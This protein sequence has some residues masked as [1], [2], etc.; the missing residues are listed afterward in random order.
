MWILR[1][2]YGLEDGGIKK[3]SICLERSI[4]YSIGRSSKNPLSIKNDKSISRQHITIKWEP[5]GQLHLVN[6]GKLTSVKERYLAI[7]ESLIFN[8]VDTKELDVHLG[9]NPVIV[10]IRWQPMNLYIPNMYEQ[11]RGLLTKYGIEVTSDILQEDSHIT[12][13]VMTPNDYYVPLLALA[14]G[15]PVFKSQYLTEV[16]NMLRPDN[17]TFDT[18]VQ[19][20]NSMESLKLV[21]SFSLSNNSKNFFQD[22][23]FII[24]LNKSSVSEHADKSFILRKSLQLIGGE[25]EII[26]D[27]T[28]LQN[29]VTKILSTSG[30]NIVIVTDEDNGKRMIMNFECRNVKDI[31]DSFVKNDPKLLK[32]NL[33]ETGVVSPKAPEIFE[34]EKLMVEIQEPPIEAAITEEST[35]S[36]NLKH[37]PPE[38]V[39]THIV[40]KRRLARKRVKPLESLD[41]FVGG[42]T[43]GT[44][45]ETS[46]TTLQ[47]EII[48]PKVPDVA[49][50][51]N[52][53]IQQ[54]QVNKSINEPAKDIYSIGGSDRKETAALTY[55]TIDKHMQE[56]TQQIDDIPS[57]HIDISPHG[58]SNEQEKRSNSSEKSPMITQQVND[59]KDEK[60]SNAKALK[61]GK[62]EDS[63]R[64]SETT[65]KSMVE[66]IQDIKN[67]EVTRLQS[68]IAHVD[69]EELTEDAINEFSN[70]AIV[71]SNASLIRRT[72]NNDNTNKSTNSVVRHDSPDNI[73]NVLEG[74]RNFKRFV[75]VYPKYIQ[76][77]NDS[78]NERGDNG[79]SDFIR[80]NAF[81]IT[82]NYVPLK[83]YSKYDDSHGGKNG[84][85]DE[86]MLE[87]EYVEYDNEEAGNGLSS[88]QH[89]NENGVHLSATNQAH[90]QRSRSSQSSYNVDADEDSNEDDNIKSFSFS[91]TSLPKEPAPNKLFVPDEDED[92]DEDEVAAHNLGIDIVNPDVR[93]VPEVPKR[94]PEKRKKVSK[95]SSPKGRGRFIDMENVDNDS[96]GDEDDDDDE[97][98]FKFRRKR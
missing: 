41:F 65:P 35:S 2:Q 73:M 12:A 95:K 29:S 96:V 80:N 20:I 83:Q 78:N 56:P 59:E 89:E 66:T 21:P 34:N 23:F 92:E 91:R 26:K 86:E 60:I 15:I 37:T 84:F 48:E 45:F 94:N 16:S 61:I 50:I 22:Y 19:K 69:A 10:Q 9:T 25:E 87:K 58:N 1:Y 30:K 17:I 62:R 52:E 76:N 53:Q 6:Q 67:R 74:R 42:S 85:N 71:E 97:P 57:Q 32:S 81:L 63:K 49:P 7:D 4:A 13:V 88:T 68:S 33:T 77:K 55:A 11:F 51:L 31:F 18:D 93:D 44:P 90:F 36:K 5:S 3:V 27:P 28:E 70:L 40:K 98:K 43:T 79:A 54:S 24:T 72:E 75:K 38:P 39:T 47:Q 14:L 8:V 46:S 82:R 64:Y